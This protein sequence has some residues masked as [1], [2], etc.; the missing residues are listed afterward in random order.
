[1]RYAVALGALDPYALADDAFTDLPV[2]ASL[3]GGRL[4]LEASV[5]SVTG[6]ELSSV[7][8]IAGG[9]LEIRVF[10][11]SGVPTTV[12]VRSGTTSKDHPRSPGATL[13]GKLV[14]LRGHFVA[15]FEGTFELGPHRIGTLR[16]AGS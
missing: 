1:L 12:E 11:P 5:L 10:N 4:P 2:V 3:G 6:A 7:R 16:L 14:D 15:S 8:R 13:R 9:V